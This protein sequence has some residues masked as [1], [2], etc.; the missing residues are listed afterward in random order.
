MRT[1]NRID[2]WRLRFV[3]WPL[4]AVVL[5]LVAASLAFARSRVSKVIVYNDTGAAI[6]ELTISACGQSR[7]FRDVGERDSVRLKLASAGSASELVLA[8]NGVPA[9]R[10]EYI[11]PTGG[12][13]AVVRLRAGGQTTCSTW[14]SCWQRWFSSNGN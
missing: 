9:W 13:R 11:E 12:Y 2:W 4:I 8:T 10:G 3:Q 6:A 14:I 1:P 7:T 5:L